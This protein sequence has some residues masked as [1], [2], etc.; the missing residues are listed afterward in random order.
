L[1]DIEVLLLWLQTPSAPSVLSLTPPL[2]SL[3]SVELL[4]VNIWISIHKTLAGPLKETAISGSFQQA[5]FSIYNSISLVI[6]SG[7]NP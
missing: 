6:V 5:F 3:H 7:M 2:G 1:V 4:A